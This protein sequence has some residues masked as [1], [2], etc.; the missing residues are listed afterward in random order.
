MKVTVVIPAYNEEER[1]ESAVISVLKQNYKDTEIIVVDNNSK[2]RTAEKVKAYASRGVRL[3]KEEKQGLLYARERG[4]LEAEGEIIANLDAD[5][6][7]APD[8]IEKGIKYFT[9]E[10]VVA[11]SGIYDYHDGGKFFR[12]SSQI[13]QKALYPVLHL[14]IHKILHIGAAFISGNNF[15]RKSAL[16]KAGGYTKSSML[17]GEDVDTGKKMTKMG[18]VIFA[19][20]LTVLSSARRFNKLGTLNLFWQYMINDLWVLVFDRPFHKQN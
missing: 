6:I 10:K 2:D 3:V 7:P 17:N 20:E 13:T 5:S 19:P 16:D 14:I 1:I 4:R 9:D 15:I 11:V 18:K 12:I 8:W